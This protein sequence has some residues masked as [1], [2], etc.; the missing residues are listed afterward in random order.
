MHG[1]QTRVFTDRVLFHHRQQGTA[2]FFKYT[3]EL[4]NGRKDYMFGS[5]PLWQICRAVYRLTKKPFILGGCL[6]IVGYFWAMVTRT[7]KTV[8]REFT[9]FR[10]KEQMK[11]L[12]RLLRNLFQVHAAKS[13]IGS[14]E[15]DSKQ[16]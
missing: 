6:L 16:T 5:H 13:G 10:R 9:T 15:V 14:I 8:S 11:R 7:E 4:S 12:R 3:V 2:Q 1:W